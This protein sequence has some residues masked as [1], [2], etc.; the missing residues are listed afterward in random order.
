ML[1]IR[2]SLSAAL[3]PLVLLGACS[4]SPTAKVQLSG[5]PVDAAS[6]D[7]TA[8]CTKPSG[9][10]NS[11]GIM[12]NDKGRSATL[13]VSISADEKKVTAVILSP[14]GGEDVFGTQQATI[15]KN[16]NTYVIESPLVKLPAQAAAGK[17]HV[18]VTC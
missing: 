5:T 8:T 11:H 1:Q 7:W 12:A 10:V 17:V 14:A 9:S 18:E 4:S 3:L 16:G 13:H 6:G 15:T 2:P